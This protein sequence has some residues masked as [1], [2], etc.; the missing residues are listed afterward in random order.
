MHTYRM[1]KE[2]NFEVGYYAPDHRFISE[3]RR[4]S[5]VATWTTLTTFKDE[6]SAIMRVNFLNGGSSNF[7]I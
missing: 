2:G 7:G 1:N 3:D 5:A 6:H 4:Y